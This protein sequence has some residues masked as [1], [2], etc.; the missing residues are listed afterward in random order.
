MK[1]FNYKQKNQVIS[2]KPIVNMMT[3]DFGEWVAS[4]FCHPQCCPFLTHKNSIE[5]NKLLLASVGK[6]EDIRACT[7]STF[8]TRYDTAILLEF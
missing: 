4:K 8:Q 1:S 3:S 5:T 2:K 6:R 7:I